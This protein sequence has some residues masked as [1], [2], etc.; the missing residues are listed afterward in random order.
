MVTIE[1]AEDDESQGSPKTDENEGND[2][3]P[4]AWKDL[5]G[6]DIRFRLLS[7]VSNTKDMHNFPLRYGYHIL[8]LTQTGRQK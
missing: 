7:S 5:M 3:D 8:P 2:E 6:K 4:Y 1:D